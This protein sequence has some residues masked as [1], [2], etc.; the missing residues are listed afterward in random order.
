[1][2][3][4][5]MRACDDAGERTRDPEREISLVCYGSKGGLEDCVFRIKTERLSACR[6]NGM[7]GTAYAVNEVATGGTKALTR[8]IRR[9][10]APANAR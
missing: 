10:D 8:R 2:R 4:S 9:G 3:C 5:V 6:I 7:R 1:M